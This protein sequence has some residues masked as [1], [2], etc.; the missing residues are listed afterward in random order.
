MAVAMA[1]TV[2]PVVLLAAALIKTIAVHVATESV[3]APMFWEWMFGRLRTTLLLDASG[4]TQHAAGRNATAATADAG[5]GDDVTATAAVAAGHGSESESGRQL[6]GGGGRVAL[7]CLQ[8]SD[9]PVR[10]KQ[11]VGGSE[12]VSQL[13]EALEPGALVWIQSDVPYIASS[14]RSLFWHHGGFA[15]SARHAA[16]PGTGSQ[17]RRCRQDIRPNSPKRN[18]QCETLGGDAT[19][20]GDVVVSEAATT[21]AAAIGAAEGLPLL[22]LEADLETHEEP[23]LTESQVAAVV[24]QQHR[25]RPLEKGRKG[26]ANAQRD[27][28]C[29]K[30][31]SENQQQQLEKLGRHQ[32]QQQEEQQPGCGG[33]MQEGEHEQN[34]EGICVYDITNAISGDSEGAKGMAGG[35]ED[36]S[37]SSRDGDGVRDCSDGGSNHNNGVDDGDGEDGWQGLPWLASNPLGVPTEREV[38]VERGGRDI[39]RLL[40]VRVKPCGRGGGC[41]MSR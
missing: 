33:G 41:V 24:A 21:V 20:Y 37:S 2:A 23:W 28:A 27:L 22:L 7:V 26:T 17:W 16:T 19:G 14:F 40:L 10:R 1:A 39:Y 13:A 15:P 12:L 18:E 11:L 32:Q 38:Y 35:A 6:C 4:A 5:A 25:R 31:S 8:F 3:A 9:P 29:C 30:A 36:A 34:G